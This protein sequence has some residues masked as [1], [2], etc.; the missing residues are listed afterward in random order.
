MR[1][2]LFFWYSFIIFVQMKI[3]SRLEK[4]YSLLPTFMFV[5]AVRRVDLEQVGFLV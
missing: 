1:C 3:I 2:F 5:I 4:V